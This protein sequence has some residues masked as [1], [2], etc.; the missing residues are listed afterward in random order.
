MVKNE[1]DE[2]G[3]GNLKLTVSQ[4]WTDGRNWFFAC[5]CKFRKARSWLNDFWVGMFKNGYGPLVHETLKY[6]VS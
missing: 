5:C 6:A 3:H 4:K 1:C 2:S